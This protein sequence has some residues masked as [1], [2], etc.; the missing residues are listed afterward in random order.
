[1]KAK[2]K[3]LWRSLGA[4]RLYNRLVLQ[5]KNYQILMKILVPVKRVVDA[6]IKVKVSPQGTIDTD[7]LKKAM[8]PFDEIALEQAV[9]MR[10]KGLATEVVAVSIGKQDCSETLRVALAMGADR[11]VLVQ[12]DKTLEPINVAKVLKAV[13]EKEAPGLVITGKQSVDAD[14]NQVGQML[15]A[16]CN[17]PQAT[18]ASEASLQDGKL[19]VT[20][21]ID[22][23]KET[24]EVTLPAVI[25]AD[26][27][28]N[29]PR[30][31]TLPMMMKAKKKPQEVIKLDDLGV[32]LKDH[33]E[34]VG[35]EPPEARKVG[36]ILSSVDELIDR[37]KNEAKVL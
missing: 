31:V 15:A 2:I 21:E 1:M 23:G 4:M 36:V 25:T 18:H 9:Q 30:Y 14:A 7:S 28:L 33:A 6:N 26:L 13:V 17:W 16:I 34:V 27:R 35:L 20:R 3:G 37:I 32:T 5:R 22:G 10:E 29:A 12:T 24:L 11:A 8:N 19:R